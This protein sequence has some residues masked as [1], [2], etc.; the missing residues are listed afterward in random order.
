MPK[1]GENIRKRKDGRWEARFIVGRDCNGKAR[2]RSVYGKSYTEAKEKAKSEQGKK[3]TQKQGNDGILFRDLLEQW[4]QNS[5][6][7]YKQSTYSKYKY[8]IDS[9]L[10]PMVGEMQVKDIDTAK[11][12]FLLGNKMK[13][14]GL[15]RGEPLSP[16]YVRTMAVILKAVLD[17][18]VREEI[19]GFLKPEIYKPAMKNRKIHTLTH[20]EYRQLQGHCQKHLNVTSIGILIA[21]GTGL[22]VGELCALRWKDIDAR[23]QLLHVCQTV[24]RMKDD[25]GKCK[26]LMEQP[27]TASSVRDIPIPDRLMEYLLQMEGRSGSAYVVSGNEN[28]TNPRT[29]EYR[30]HKEVRASNIASINFHA[31]RHTFATRCVEGGMDIKTL[32]EILGHSNASITLNTYVHSSLDLKKRQMEKVESFFQD[33]GQD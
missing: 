12:N 17:Y 23:N 31:L 6:I 28:F 1:R 25:N 26:W 19:C 5:R 18:G 16:A 20:A 24:S 9:H 10:A 14:G 2:Y 13:N 32:S 29:F 4:L 27:K 11:I 33:R 22:R 3:D 15:S 7:R 8:I 30:Y 21:L